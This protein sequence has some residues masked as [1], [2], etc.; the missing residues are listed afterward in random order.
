MFNKKQ[1]SNNFM[2]QID[3]S[4]FSLREYYLFI[5]YFQIADIFERFSNIT[6]MYTMV[7]GKFS[8]YSAS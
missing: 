4:T 6:I 2:Y 5:K 1:K 8:R 7:F 3:F